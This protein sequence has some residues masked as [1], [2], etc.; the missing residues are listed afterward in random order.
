MKEEAV[1]Q[2][3]EW[4]NKQSINNPLSGFTYMDVKEK[5]ESLLSSK[6]EDERTPLCR[7]TDNEHNWSED[8]KHENGNY[9]N[10][11]KVCNV[12]FFGHKRRVV[13]K[14]CSP[15]IPTTLNACADTG[16]NLIRV[17]SLIPTS[18][19]E[20]KEASDVSA[21]EILL[22]RKVFSALQTP[23]GA[24]ISDVYLAE[25]YLSKLTNQFKKK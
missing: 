18:E 2:F 20:K 23:D 13:C 16:A 5:L 25:S 3:I 21:E 4:L 24:T 15:S 9:E 8:F 6:G 10:V 7:I 12:L 1:Q 11:C 17:S 22:I 19:T 14:K